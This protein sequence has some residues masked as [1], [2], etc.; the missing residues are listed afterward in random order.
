MFDRRTVPIT[1]QPGR[2]AAWLRLTDGVG[3]DSLLHACALAYMS[4]DLPTDAVAS[5]H[6]DSPT[7]RLYH[8]VFMSASLD[9]SIWFHRPIEADGWQLHEFTCH[10]LLSSRGVAVGHVFTAEGLHVATVTQEV[11]VRRRE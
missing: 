1:D 2:A 4:D 6:P 5:Q 10:G 7:S 8:E 9:H 11:L 3:T